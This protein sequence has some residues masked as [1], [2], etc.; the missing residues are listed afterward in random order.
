MNRILLFILF[1]FSYVAIFAQEYIQV[2]T[3]YNKAEQWKE[4]TVELV[5]K[6]DCEMGIFNSKIGGEFTSYFE[7][8]FFDKNG[9]RLQVSYYFPAKGVPFMNA[10]DIPKAGLFFT[11]HLSLTFKYSIESLFGFCKEPEKIKKMKLKFH[12]EYVVVKDES[13]VKRDI[14]EEFSQTFKF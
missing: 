9:K 5:N 12:I 13:L 2:N 4:L 10:L 6:S 1:I 8:Y 11:P 14:F 7:L 3:S